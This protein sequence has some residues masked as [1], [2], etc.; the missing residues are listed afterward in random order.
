MNAR[1]LLLIW[2]SSL[3]LSAAQEGPPPPPP[4]ERAQAGPGEKERPGRE[5]RGDKPGKKEEDPFADLSPEERAA[6]RKAFE[7]VWS[8]PEVVQARHEISRATE[9]YQKALRDALTDVDPKLAGIVERMRKENPAGLRDRFRGRPPESDG[10]SGGPGGGA[11][12]NSRPGG[13]DFRSGL[14]MLGTPGFLG[15]LEEP[16][17]K[18]FTETSEKARKDPRVESV[19]AKLQKTRESEDTLREERVK[20]FRELRKVF[21]EVMVE[22]E[23]GLKEFVPGSFLDP[24]QEKDGKEREKEKERPKAEKKPSGELPPGPSI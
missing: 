2:V 24:G 23:P 1:L 9:A 5:G 7:K 6:L 4:R 11:P 13:R 17:R 3:G 15:K 22:I 12:G 14:D 18:L 8:D 16:Q 21:S 19:V 20:L 10:P